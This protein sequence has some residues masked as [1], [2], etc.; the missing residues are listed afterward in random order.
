MKAL[1]LSAG[2]MYGAYQAGAWKALAG[3][4]Q[5]DLVVGASIGAVNGWAIA[6]GCEPSELIERWLTL[7]AAAS[8]GWKFP[9]SLFSGVLDS[10]PLQHVIRELYDSFCPSVRFAM[11]LTDLLKLR[12]RVLRVPEIRAEHLL[13]TTAIVGLFDQIR[14]EGRVYS[15]GGLLSAV[16]LWVAAE[17]GATRALVIDV[18]PEPPGMI[19]RTFVSAMRVL[20]PFRAPSPSGLE[21]IRLAPAKLLGAPLEAIYWSREN[22]QAW[23][24][25]GERDA[26]AM[27]HS[28]ANCFE[29]Q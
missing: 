22:A 19:A 10:S 24:Q 21:L 27:K 18:L 3:V 12:P 17:M 26:D 13:A 4:F 23:I 28:I 29:R 9:R 20:S 7:E 2:G 16:P 11:V 6:G 15:D 8:Y 25:A 1:V 5:P 14:L